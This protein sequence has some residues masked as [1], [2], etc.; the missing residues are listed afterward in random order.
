VQFKLAD[1]ATQIEAARQ[2]IWHA[3]SLKDAGRPA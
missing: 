1:M 2:L 3:A